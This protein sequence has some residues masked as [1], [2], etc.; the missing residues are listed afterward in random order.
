RKAGPTAVLKPLPDGAA[1][2]VIQY[3]VLVDMAPVGTANTQPGAGGPVTTTIQTLT[4]NLD[5]MNSLSLK[6]GQAASDSIQVN[7]SR[8][9]ITTDPDTGD[10]VDTQQGAILSSS[11][12]AGTG[13]YGGDL[14]PRGNGMNDL[15][16]I[17]LVRAAG[18]FAGIDP[19]AVFGP[20]ATNPNNLSQFTVMTGGQLGTI[21]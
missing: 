13:A 1:G 6:L 18:S 17:R 15:A 20:P 10:P 4:N 12:K 11:W 5:G 19:I 14:S 3:R 7:F 9:P 2:D 16:K 21:I 8:G